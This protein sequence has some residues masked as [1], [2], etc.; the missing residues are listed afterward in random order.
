ME[1]LDR[2]TADKIVATGTELILQPLL[3]SG[4][5]SEVLSPVLWLVFLIPSP[6]QEFS[7]PLPSSKLWLGSW[8]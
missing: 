7:R 2:D 6:H 5:T 1:V 8:Q 3:K 4:W